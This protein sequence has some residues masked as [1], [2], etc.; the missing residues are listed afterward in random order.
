MPNRI[1]EKKA[2]L[3]TGLKNCKYL[4][5]YLIRINFFVSL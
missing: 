1:R 5:N 2:P 4:K 3:K